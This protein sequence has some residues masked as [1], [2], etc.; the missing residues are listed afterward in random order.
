MKEKISKAIG[1]RI[2]V[3]RAKQNISQEEL[4]FKSDLH[5]TY[6][7]A[8]ERGEKCPTIDTLLKVTDALNISL[9]EFLLNIEKD[10]KSE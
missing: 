2:K 7:G 3:L 1:N 8:I 9:S 4:S 5:R 10:V 6:I